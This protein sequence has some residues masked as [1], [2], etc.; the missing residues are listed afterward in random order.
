[1]VGDASSM[2]V[3]LRSGV[4]IL[5]LGVGLLFLKDKFCIFSSKKIQQKLELSTIMLVNF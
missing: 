4:E 3:M 2:L 1:M 5:C